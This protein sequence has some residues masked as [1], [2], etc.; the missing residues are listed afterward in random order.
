MASTFKRLVI[1]RSV[2]LFFELEAKLRVRVRFSC[3]LII[4]SRMLVYDPPGSGY[5]YQFTIHDL[6]FNNKT[7]QTHFSNAYDLQKQINIC[8][9]KLYDNFEILTTTKVSTIINECT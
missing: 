3:Q 8:N 1:W 7:I 6:I 2:F 4:D 5:G 9:P